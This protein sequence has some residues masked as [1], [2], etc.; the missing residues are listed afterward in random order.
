MGFAVKSALDKPV[1]AG[2]VGNGPSEGCGEA[3]KGQSGHTSA[4]APIVAFR[5]LQWRV[6]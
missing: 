3:S 6:H 4:N 1:R 2:S 5:L